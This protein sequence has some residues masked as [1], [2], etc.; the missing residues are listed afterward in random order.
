M[1]HVAYSAESYSDVVTINRD[2]VDSWVLVGVT[3]GV[4]SDKWRAELFA[5]NI[6]DEQAELTRNF[7]FDREQVNYAPPTTVGL[8]VTFDF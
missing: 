8:R 3:A 7:V 4:A 1:P 5:D 6:F 2:K